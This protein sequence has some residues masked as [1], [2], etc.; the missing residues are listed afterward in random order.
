MPESS[1]AL[2]YAHLRAERPRDGFASRR[3]SRYSFRATP[4][5]LRLYREPRLMARLARARGSRATWT[6]PA[7]VETRERRDQSNQ[8]DDLPF[9]SPSQMVGGIMS[10]PEMEPAGAARHGRSPSG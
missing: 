7:R 3:R 6:K 1:G 4:G 5:R 9:G 8:R 10:P 2:N